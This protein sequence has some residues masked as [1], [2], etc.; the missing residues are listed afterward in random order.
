MQ[1]NGSRSIRSI[2]RSVVIVL[3]GVLA[4]AAASA[5]VASAKYS[6]G[7]IKPSLREALDGAY[8][9]SSTYSGSWKKSNSGSS[10]TSTEASAPG[11]QAPSTYQAFSSFGDQGWYYLAPG[12]DFEQSGWVSAGTTALVNETDPFNLTAS[13]DSRSL[14]LHED[15]T[16]RTPKLCVTDEMP[17][18]RFV[19]KAARGGGQLDVEVRLYGPDGRVTDS[20]SGSVSPSDHAGWSPSRRVELKT[21]SLDPGASGYIDIVFRS[22]GDWLIDDVLI[23]PYRRR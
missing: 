18:L 15:A 16:V 23:D 5:S 8:S 10:T 20:S 12:G 17:H 22:Q 3:A 4:L 14:R 2:G 21:D 11:C 1:G 13:A 7:L 9:G 19:A 6:K